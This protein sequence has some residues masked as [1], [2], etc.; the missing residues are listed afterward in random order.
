[1]GAYRLA[2]PKGSLDT[3]YDFTG[4]M[5]VRVPRVALVF[6]RNAAVELDPSGILLDDC[7]AF[8]PNGDDRAPGIIATCSSRPSRCS[9]TSE[10]APWAS[11]AARAE[12]CSTT[13]CRHHSVCRT[14]LFVF[15]VE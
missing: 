4:V 8:A 11:A 15:C 13:C 9:T 1:M 3:C 6:D 5:V 2:P 12:L 7:L 14:P 10:A